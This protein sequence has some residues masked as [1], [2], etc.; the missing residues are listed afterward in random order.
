MA[1]RSLKEAIKYTS[2]L[3]A[4]AC[5]HNAQK[6]RRGAF[7]QAYRLMCLSGERSAHT[8]VDSPPFRRVPGKSHKFNL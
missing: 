4:I 8:A 6:A 5:H 7:T 1:A 2:I 3:Q